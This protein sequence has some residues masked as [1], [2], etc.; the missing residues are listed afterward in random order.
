MSSPDAAADAPAARFWQAA[1]PFVLLDF[2]GETRL[3]R[4]PRS[5][6][7]ASDP[8]GVDA[9]IARLE[10]VEAAG[11]IAYEAGHALERKLGDL[12]CTPAEGAPPLVWFGLFD[13]YE[14]LP[15]GA[16]P[17][18]EGAWAGAPQP[19]ITRARYEASVEA[20]REHIFAG[21]IYQANFT[22]AADVPTAGHP[23]AIYAALK[24]RARAGWGGIVFTGRHWILSLSPELFFVAAGGRVTARPMK[25][26]AAADTDPALL[27]ADPKQ[28][29]ENLMI[30]D[31]L[32]NDL[33]RVAK[34]GSVAVPELF[35]IETYPTVHQMTSTVVGELEE[36]IGPVDLLRATFPCGSVTGAP[37]IR[38]MEVIAALEEAP[39]AIYTGSI[40]R[41]APD[42]EAAF[43]VAIR[44]L[45]L[46]AGE[47]VARMGL[48]S[49][50][51]ADSRPAD[52][53]Q[54]CLAK[55]EFVETGRRFD[56][57]ETMRFDPEEGLAHLELHLTRIKRSADALGFAFD[58][59]GVRNELQAATFTL[60][61][62][63]KVRLRLSRSG[64]IAIEVRP[65]PADAEQPVDVALVALPVD[66][67]DFRLR[68]KTSDRA[69]Y[70]D[71]RLAAGC[72][73]TLF[74]DPDGFVT[75][76]SFT[77]V[78]VRRDGRLA[79]P[80]RTRGLMPGIL[81]ETLLEQGEAVERELRAADLQGGFYVGNAV[82]GLI[83][84]RLI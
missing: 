29:A 49:G 23:V 71:A 24:Q 53:W 78:F 15:P 38:A 52:E 44:T 42:G 19:L 60:R 4:N 51:V 66:P 61:V 77:N 10:G 33:A 18:P 14:S 68:H 22:F 27:R 74:V 50:I 67:D 31:L 3:Y 21:D 12:R 63:R 64:A 75:E 79:T 57:I 37:K 83:A 7:E 47:S 69:F 72:F 9:A 25:G 39:R 46:R 81:R 26:T 82:R 45:T 16:L 34:P 48:G 8:D 30:V 56:L 36:G 11:F 80:P 20:V 6:V 43:N 1:K 65:L 58:R 55:G 59:H 17:D 2:Q 28:Q 35:A 40:G 73:E 54:E 5:I 62:G 13:G 32:R 76:G 41:V 84:A 70:D